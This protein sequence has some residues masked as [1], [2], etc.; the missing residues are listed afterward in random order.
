MLKIECMQCIFCR[1]HLKIKEN[2]TSQIKNLYCAQVGSVATPHMFPSF[3]AILTYPESPQDSP[4]LFFTIQKSSS[5]H[6]KKKSLWATLDLKYVP[7]DSFYLADWWGYQPESHTPLPE[8]RDSDRYRNTRGHGISLLCKAESI[9]FL[10]KSEICLKNDYVL[11]PES[12][13]VQ[14]QSQLTQDL[15]ELRQTWGQ[16]RCPGKDQ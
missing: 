16:S 6:A 1:S 5:A 7:F 13:G 3:L 14:R 8:L 12:F 4:Q 9:F 11:L 15:F 2:N 10:A